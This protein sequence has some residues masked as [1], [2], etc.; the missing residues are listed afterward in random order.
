MLNKVYYFIIA[1]LLSIALFTGYLSYSFYGQKQVLDARLEQQM[2]II[3]EKDRQLSL[4]RDATAITA[5]T[6]AEAAKQTEELHETLGSLVQAIDDL[7]RNKKEPHNEKPAVNVPSA[8]DLQL[9]RLLD[10]AYC[11]ANPADSACPASG[12][13]N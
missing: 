10:A 13:K 8:D 11:T 5:N 6:T 1:G 7:E 9:Q 12:T 2:F 3:K 4:L